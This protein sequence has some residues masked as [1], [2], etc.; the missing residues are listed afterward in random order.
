MTMGS[1]CI[2]EKNIALCLTPREATV[3]LRKILLRWIVLNDA[4]QELIWT[5]DEAEAEDLRQR[6]KRL[7][8]PLS[9]QSQSNLT[10]P[11]TNRQLTKLL[12]KP[13]TKPLTK[14]KHVAQEKIYP[15]RAL[16]SDSQMASETDCREE[17][18]DYLVFW[19]FFLGSVSI[20]FDSCKRQS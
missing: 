6:I 16:W 11:L 10:E 8:R 19:R 5:A 18:D 4:G 1:T 17:K 20:S 14:V 13:V 12:S 3:E 2:R 9:H 7:T 15:R